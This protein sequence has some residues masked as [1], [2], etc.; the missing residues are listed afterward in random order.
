MISDAFSLK[1]PSVRIRSL[2]LYPFG[3]SITSVPV[4][5]ISSLLLEGDQSGHMLLEG[6]QSG[7]LLLEGFDLFASR[8][9]KNASVRIRSG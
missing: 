6:D 4:E 2:G 7:V 8:S 5:E 9:L 3:P 1:N